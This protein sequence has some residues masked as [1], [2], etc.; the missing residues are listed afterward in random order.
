MINSKEKNKEINRRRFSV[1]LFFMT[2]FSWFKGFFFCHDKPFELKNVVPS[3]Y[4]VPKFQGYTFKR[5]KKVR[6][7]FAYGWVKNKK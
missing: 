7:F 1:A 6:N 5:I 3:K 4:F 2:I